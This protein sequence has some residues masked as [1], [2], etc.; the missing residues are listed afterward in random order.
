MSSGFYN[1][2]RILTQRRGVHRSNWCKYA[3]KKKNLIAQRET[4]RN[5][6]HRREKKIFNGQENGCAVSSWYSQ[7]Q[8]IKIL[9]QR[10]KGRKEEYFAKT[11]EWIGVYPGD[12]AKAKR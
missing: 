8:K 7:D 6:L 5:S 12:T 10:R 9:T 4:A 1:K 2:I 3:E 11:R